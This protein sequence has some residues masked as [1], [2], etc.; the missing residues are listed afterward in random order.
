MVFGGLEEAT[1][2]SSQD[3]D[4]S[5]R[6]QEITGDFLH[7]TGPTVN[8]QAQMKQKTNKDKCTIHF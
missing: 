5:E 7:S 6:A 1:D 2:R 8:D 4:V 3:N